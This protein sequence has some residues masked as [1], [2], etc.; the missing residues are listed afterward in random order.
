MNE[1]NPQQLFISIGLSE[2]T[3]SETVKDA[4]LSSQL[5]TC[6]DSVVG[7]ITAK[8]IPPVKGRLLYHVACQIKPQIIN[9]MPILSQFV[10]EGKI[11]SE[12][13]LTAG[14][15][16]L[17]SNPGD[18]DIQALEEALDDGLT[19]A[20]QLFLFEQAAAAVGTPHS[21]SNHK[22]FTARKSCSPPAQ[23]S[24][25]ATAVKK[26]ESNAPPK[27]SIST[28]AV[29]VAPPANLP[30]LPE[31]ALLDNLQQSAPKRQRVK[32]TA[33]KNCGGFAVSHH[34]QLAHVVRM[35]QVNGIP[36][37]SPVVDTPKNVSDSVEKETVSSSIDST[38]LVGCICSGACNCAP[39]TSRPTL[40]FFVV[41]TPPPKEIEVFTVDSDSD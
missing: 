29:E 12:L 15:D 16:Y 8:E 3:A 28:P 24:N 23:P 19:V 7:R 14:L 27:P 9:H 25:N 34:R 35:K 39:S 6:I 36:P 41:E 11:D 13:S 40:D 17:L 30:V 31:T 20:T 10:M 1:Y 37:P 33:R 38:G 22:T 21:G 26:P 18:V 4:V 32:Q 2:E 5:K